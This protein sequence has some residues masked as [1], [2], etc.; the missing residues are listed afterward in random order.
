MPVK[1]TSK[2]VSIILSGHKQKY[3]LKTSL[4]QE[5]NDRWMKHTSCRQ[6]KKQKKQNKVDGR[7][8]GLVESRPI[9]HIQCHVHFHCEL[10]PYK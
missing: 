1:F 6:Q 5:A 2:H 7:P 8:P 3:D 4:S 10:E 9:L